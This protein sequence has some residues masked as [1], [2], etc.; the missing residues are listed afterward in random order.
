MFAGDLDERTFK[1][2]EKEDFR[3]EKEGSIDQE[4]CW[5]TKS[6]RQGHGERPIESGFRRSEAWTGINRLIW[7]V[8]G[9]RE[10]MGGDHCL[11]QN[12][13]NEKKEKGRGLSCRGG[14]DEL[15]TILNNGVGERPVLVMWGDRNGSDLSG[16]GVGIGK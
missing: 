1:W 4:R 6:W 13:I 3:I 9:A 11:R 14:K 5:P 8:Y 16:G 2:E 7:S 10:W 12:M 15:G